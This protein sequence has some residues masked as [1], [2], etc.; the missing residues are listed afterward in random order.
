MVSLY[1][2][3]EITSYGFAVSKDQVTKQEFLP[4]PSLNT[5]SRYVFKIPDYCTR[6]SSPLMKMENMVYDEGD[7][8]SRLSAR[9]KATNSCQF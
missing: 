3:N 4:L 6:P 2:L 9:C 8:P 1:I 5:T 7:L